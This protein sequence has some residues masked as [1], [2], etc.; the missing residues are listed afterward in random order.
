MQDLP[1]AAKPGSRPQSSQPLDAAILSVLECRHEE[2]KDFQRSFSIRASKYTR[3]NA[4]AL[5]ATRSTVTAGDAV[6]TKAPV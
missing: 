1:L 3:L 5:A 2:V 6:L 4:S